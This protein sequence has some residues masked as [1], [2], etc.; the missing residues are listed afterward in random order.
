MPARGRPAHTPTPEP[1]PGGTGD[2]GAR[3]PHTH[4]SRAPHSH[5]PNQPPAGPAMPARGRPA[6]TPTPTE[7]T[8]GGTGDADSRAPG[9]HTP[10]TNWVNLAKAIV[11]LLSFCA[12]RLRQSTTGQSQTKKFRIWGVRF[13]TVGAPSPFAKTGFARLA[14]YRKPVEISGNVLISASG[15]SISKSPPKTRSQPKA[16]LSLEY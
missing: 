6:H 14:H 15:Q 9:T 5:Q 10:R 12:S 13:I 1:T 3:A 16:N 2:A 7:P 4:T 8:P 11:S